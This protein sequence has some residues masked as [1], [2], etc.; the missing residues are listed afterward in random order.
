MMAPFPPPYPST[1]P[2]IPDDPRSPCHVT[3]S[4]K[5]CNHVWVAAYYPMEAELF[6]RILAR[7]TCPMCGNTKP[8]MGKGA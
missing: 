2:L 4:D 7:A 3:C 5:A 8:Y 6:C 1:N